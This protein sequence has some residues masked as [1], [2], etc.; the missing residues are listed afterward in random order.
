MIKHLRWKLTLFN[1]AITGAI[2]MCLVVLGLFMAEKGV[3]ETAFDGFSRDLNTTC[4]YLGDTQRLSADWLRQLES[5][6]G[7]LLSIRDGER[8]L[9]SGS[10]VSQHQQLAEQF[11][12]AREWAQTYY[13]NA[14]GNL[15]FPMRG[16]DGRGYFAGLA[17]ISKNGGQLEV[18]MLHPLASMEASIWR[19]RIVVLAASVLALGALWAFS[20]C[21]TGRMLQPIA[22]NQ[23]RQAQFIA[24]ASHELRTPLTAILS[25]A[26]AMERAEENQRR[27]FADN[28]QRE[29]QRMS[30]LI[31]DML[32]LASA[33]SQSWQLRLA[34]VELDMLLLDVYE[35]YSPR[36]REKGL[37][38]RLDL[39]E[40]PGRERMLDKDRMVQVLAILLDNA[41]SYTPAPGEISMKLLWARSGP[42]IIVSDTGPGIP[43]AEKQ[44]IFERFHRGSQG[45]T[46]RSHFGLGLCIAKEIITQ[47]NGRI[48]AQNSRDGGAEFVIELPM[49]DE[50]TIDG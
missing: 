22:E 17:Q 6:G 40:Q 50:L 48:W 15:A 44:Q 3:R 30:R 42:R 32:T 13:P 12:Q 9:F 24:S 14:Q 34:P 47:H 35:C 38:L 41:L 19:Q 29:G 45:H 16:T 23:R 5:A 28:I 43:D 21:F 8:P 20:W 27:L 7:S 37:R 31:G 25:S 2:L 11:Q 10:L 33:D 36:A 1:T 49:E 39:P 18:M 26:S 46:S 4:T